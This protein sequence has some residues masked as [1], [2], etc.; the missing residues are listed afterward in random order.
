MDQLLNSDPLLCREL[1]GRTHELQVL[2]KVLQQVI[3]GQPH[4][5]LL[6]GEA[7]VGKTKLCRVFLERSQY[8]HPLILSGQAIPQDQTL[9]FGPFLDAFRRYFSTPAGANL[10]SESLLQQFPSELVSLFPCS[11]RT[12]PAIM[13]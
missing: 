9:L 3:A 6:S 7:G 12:I 10:L 1:I 13:K 11:R 4:F 2:S 5:V 8:H